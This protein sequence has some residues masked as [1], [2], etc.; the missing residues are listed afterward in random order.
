MKRQQFV[1]LAGS[2]AAASLPLAA[3]A[4][5]PFAPGASVAEPSL[6]TTAAVRPGDWVQYIM[7]SGV[8]YA[9]RIAFGR[10][11]TREGL[12][13]YIETEIGGAGG[14]CNPNTVKKAYLRG[15]DFG[16]L[17]TPHEAL[18]FVQKAGTAYNLWGGPGGE[19]LSKRDATFWLLDESY[20]YVRRRATIAAIASDRVRLRHRTVDAQRITVEFPRAAAPALKRLTVWRSAAVPLGVVKMH[21]EIAG[22]DPFELK[23]DFHGER[24]VSVVPMTLDELRAL[25]PSN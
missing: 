13:S 16:N 5:A 8:Q 14:S 1:S 4:R 12:L 23:L 17:V 21:A 11:R 18:L 20:F 7:G 9:K 6:F 10:E 25:N 19:P 2:L 22:A 24:Y 3:T 15:A